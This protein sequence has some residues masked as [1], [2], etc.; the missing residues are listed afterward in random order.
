MKRLRNHSEATIKGKIFIVFIA[1]I[2]LTQLRNDIQKIKPK[3]RHYWSEREFLDRVANYT[4]VHFYNKYK[5]VFTVPTK[6][7]R[8]IFDMMG[9]EYSYKG[10]KHNAIEPKATE[11]AKETLSAPSAD[12]TP[13]TGEGS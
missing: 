12:N 1:L 3:D 13:P 8:D 9:L 4:K 6:M 2:L 5:D 7:Q 11:T 10:E